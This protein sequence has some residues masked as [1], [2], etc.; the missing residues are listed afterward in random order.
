MFAFMTLFT[1]THS[2]ILSSLFVMMIFLL[3]SITPSF[4]FRLG[5]ADPLI[6]NIWLEPENPEPGDVISIHS[7]IYNQG[8]QSTKEV[9][10]VVTIGYFI[11]GNLVKIFPLTDVRPGV[12]NGIEI[13]T[14]V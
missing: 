6:N 5:D 14:G 3:S 8:T 11:D 10:N 7:S 12:E 13:S 1:G 4:A 2:I 9:T